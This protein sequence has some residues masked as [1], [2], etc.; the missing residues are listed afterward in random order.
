[1]SLFTLLMPSYMRLTICVN[2]YMLA[3]DLFNLY[4]SFEVFF[5]ASYVLLTLVASPAR[6]RAGVGYV[7]VSMVSSMNFLLGIGLTYAAVGTVNMAQ[8]GIR[9]QDIPEGTRTA[10]FGV[11][12]VRSEEHTS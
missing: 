2:V 11:L 12:L 7:M 8:I 6:V 3:G 5:V 1:D 9:I 4:F 10:I